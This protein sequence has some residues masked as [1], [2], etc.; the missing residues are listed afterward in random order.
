MRG[1]LGKSIV[2]SAW[3]GRNYFRSYVV[4]ANPDSA[5]QKAQ[6]DKNKKAMAEWQTEVS[7]IPE[8]IAIYNALA[9]NRLIAGVN[10]FMK[11][12]LSVK[13]EATLAGAN[14]EVDYEIFHDVGL[15]GLYGSKDGATVTELQ[16]AGELLGNGP[17]QYVHTAPASGVWEYFIGYAD[18]FDGLAGA[19][20]DAV[21]CAHW[22]NNDA[23]G[24]ADPATATKP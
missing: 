5:K 23:T 18:V 15:L 14:I 19:D 1:K 22:L 2:G 17:Q 7:Q 10:L 3:K 11:Q 16:T 6:R 12:A 8:A 21:K 20:V 13:I 24:E 4:P 9:L